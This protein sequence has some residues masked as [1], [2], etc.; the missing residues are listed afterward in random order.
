MNSETAVSEERRAGRKKDHPVL[1]YFL[2]L[3]FVYFFIYY[4]E[5]LDD[6]LSRFVPGFA[7]EYT[8]GGVTRQS[9][10]GPGRRSAR[11]RRTESFRSS[12]APRSGDI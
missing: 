10:S 1:Q 3:F 5:M 2:L 7:F 4:G 6:A 11:W 12:T 8:A 9:A